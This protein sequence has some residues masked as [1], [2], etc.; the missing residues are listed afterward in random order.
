MRIQ[1]NRDLCTGNLGFCERCLSRLFVYPTVYKRDCLDILDDKQDAITIEVRSG[2]SGA[3]F[4]L[5]DKLQTM[6][7]GE[8]F[9]G[10]TDLALPDSDA[11]N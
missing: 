7:A 11:K 10:F 4:R 5:D 3:L 1:I 6:M 2:A 8:S 9:A